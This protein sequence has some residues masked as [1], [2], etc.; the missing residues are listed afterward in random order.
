M[1]SL[2]FQKLKCNHFDPLC[3]VISGQAHGDLIAIADHPMDTH[4]IGASGGVN[5]P[6]GIPYRCLLP[7]RSKNLMI[8]GRAASFSA[9]AASSCR[10][11]RTMMQLGEAA[12]VA[13]YIASR[14]NISL[15]E[16]DV[17]EIRSLMHSEI[18]QDA[19]VYQRQ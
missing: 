3:P 13:A 18:D 15:R 16:V 11:S 8:A 7:L 1:C 9:L 17:S 19:G 2:W 10:L 14:D 4:G 12:G 6:Y 5:A